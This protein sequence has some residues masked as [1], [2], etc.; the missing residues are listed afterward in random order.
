MSEGEAVH[1]S[2]EG[3]DAAAVGSTSAGSGHAARDANV[4]WNIIVN[5]LDISI[6]AGGLGFISQV[7]ILPLFVSTLT[8][9][10]MAIGLIGAIYNLGWVPQVLVAGRIERLRYR[11]HWVLAITTLERIALLLMAG[12]A[13]FLAAS[14]P[15]LAL[16]GFFLALALHT[17]SA[18]LGMPAWLDMIGKTIPARLRGRFFGITMLAGQGFGAL[19]AAAAAWLLTQ[20][21]YPANFGGTFLVGFVVLAVGF[22]PLALVREPPSPPPAR[23]AIPVLRYLQGLGPVLERDRNFSRFLVGGALVSLSAAGAGFVA[24]YGSGPLGL[25]EATVAELAVFFMVAQLVAN[26]LLGWLCDRRGYLVAMVVAGGAATAAALLALGAQSGMA[27]GAVFALLGVRQAAYSLSALNAGLEFGPPDIRPTYIALTYLVLSSAAAAGPMLGGAVVGAFGFVPLFAGT[28]LCG[29][30]GAAVLLAT[31]R[32][33]RRL[34][35]AV[36][37]VE[38]GEARE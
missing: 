1:P 11:L 20:F 18:G 32:E 12:I 21:A 16:I 5:G 6:F 29:A 10:S 31:V 22:I 37:G 4:R 26:P 24:I 38:G 9:S 23:P 36:A 27:L 19:C 3:L 35:R 34:A 2:E 28:A 33:P 13:F 7:G 8:D 14:S 30:L 15:A 17:F 25:A